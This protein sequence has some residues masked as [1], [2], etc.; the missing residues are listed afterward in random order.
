[1]IA[2]CYGNGM[3]SL[4]IRLL[5]NTIITELV[6]VPSRTDCFREEIGNRVR[7]RVKVKISFTSEFTTCSYPGFPWNSLISNPN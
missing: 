6:I 2:S 5:I 3:R 7:F 4:I 1:M